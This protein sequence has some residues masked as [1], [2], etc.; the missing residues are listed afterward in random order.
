[1]AALLLPLRA[2]IAVNSAVLRVGRTIAW[3]LIGLMT[4][5][6]LYQVFMRYALNAA[7]NWTEEF[8]RFMMLWMTGLIAPSAYR[9]GGFVAIDMISRSLPRIMAQALTILL[10]LLGTIV[11]LKAVQLGVN[12]VKGGCLFNSSTL[13]VPF[14]LK[15]WPCTDV[16]EWNGWGNTRL[17]LSYMYMS[18]F[19]GVV[20]L[21]SVNIELILRTIVGIVAP[22]TQLPQDPEMGAVQGAE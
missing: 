20:L 1:M 6:I 16:V 9:W 4:C 12:H 3:V 11:L 15:I 5:V 10:F 7:P 21:L 22:G 18:L 13:R 19:V 8:A 2:L 14:D 17:K